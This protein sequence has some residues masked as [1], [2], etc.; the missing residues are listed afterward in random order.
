MGRG[1]LCIAKQ[2]SRS[3]AILRFA[4]AAGAVPVRPARRLLSP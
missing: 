2:N 1:A 3:K 4:P